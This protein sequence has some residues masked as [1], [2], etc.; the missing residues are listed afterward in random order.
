MRLHA[1]EFNAVA[2]APDGL[3]YGMSKA[4]LSAY[5]RV[6]ARE[7]PTLLVNSCSPGF[8]ETGTAGE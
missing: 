2:M 3:Y 7:Q 6:V 4:L 1:G 5:T 8:I